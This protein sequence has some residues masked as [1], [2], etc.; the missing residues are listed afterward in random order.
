MNGN[1][2]RRRPRVA[3][4]GA[5]RLIVPGREPVEAAVADLSE[6][7]CG[8]RAERAVE[9]GTQVRISGAGFEGEGVVRY[10]YRQRGAW[11]VGVELTLPDQTLWGDAIL[12]VT[13]AWTG[14]S[15]V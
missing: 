7:G 10:C 2:R 4:Q 5:V 8:L 15:A 6:I 14:S 13:P 1:E 11:R 3:W 12:D 9:P